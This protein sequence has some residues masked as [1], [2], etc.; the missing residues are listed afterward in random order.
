MT[1]G[2]A[3]DLTE[4]RF[5]RLVVLSRAS[6]DRQ[7]NA[8]W[9]CKCDCGNSVAV[10]ASFLKRGQSFCSKQCPLHFRSD[11]AGKKFGRLLATH[12]VGKGPKSKAIWNFRCDCG[13]EVERIADQVQ[14][15][16]VASCGCLGIESRIKH[17][18][19]GSRPYQNAA[20]KRWA[21]QNPS[22][23]IA[24]ANKRRADKATRTPKWLTDEQWSAMDEFYFHAQKLSEETGV[25]HHVDHIVP[26]RGKRVSGLHVPWNLAVIT[27]TENLRK[28]AR[29]L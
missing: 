14:Q 24:N 25:V 9:M 3:T 20:H 8:Q 2:I 26:L 17:G 12:V 16:F 1:R 18:Q 22:K 11:I 5:G 6:S 13:N 7:G 23:V 27:A 15:G 4:R 10:R 21:A 28:S 19:S 29:Y